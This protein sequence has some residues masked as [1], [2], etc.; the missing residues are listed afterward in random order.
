MADPFDATRLD[1]ELH[2]A[3]LKIHGCSSKGRIDWIKPPTPQELAVAKKV[4]A[5]HDKDKAQ[6]EEAASQARIAA[7]RE[8]LAEKDL[9]LK[10]LNELARLERGMG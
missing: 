10:E 3:G 1:S 9:T 4:L 6:R 8:K 7:L 2:T 5:A